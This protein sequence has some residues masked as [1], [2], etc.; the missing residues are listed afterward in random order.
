MYAMFIPPG[1]DC[2]ATCTSD[3]DSDRVSTRANERAS[4][5]RLDSREQRA[6]ARWPVR[7]P[8]D[9]RAT[10]V[11]RPSDVRPTPPTTARGRTRTWNTPHS[12]LQFPPSKHPSVHRIHPTPP[13]HATHPHKFHPNRPRHAPAAA[14]MPRIYHSSYRLRQS[15][16]SATP[17]APALAVPV[18]P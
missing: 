17:R 11:R 16:P 3:G 4:S 6:T 1:G 9:A 18:V 2:I 7:R 10:S 15:S 14:D 5:R 12:T 8:S 13:H